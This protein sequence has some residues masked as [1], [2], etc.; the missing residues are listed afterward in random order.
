MKDSFSRRHGF[1]L[2]DE[3]EITVRE[4]AP[5]AMQEYLIQLSYECGLKPSGLRQI[6]CQTLKV[7]RPSA[8]PV[9]AD[10]PRHRVPHTIMM[11]SSP[12]L[13]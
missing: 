12:E 1:F 6:I 9:C 2:V 3:A 8:H 4:D 7:L 11:T 13:T 10:V 5:Q